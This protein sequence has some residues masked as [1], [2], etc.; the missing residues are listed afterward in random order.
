M[1]ENTRKALLTHLFLII[2]SS[3]VD[4]ENEN[5][6]AESDLNTPFYKSFLFPAQS[7]NLSID[8]M[9]ASGSGFF[10]ISM[11]FPINKGSGLRDQKA[12]EIMSHFVGKSLVYNDVKVK[13]LTQPSFTRLTNTADRYVGAVRIT[14][15]S[16]KL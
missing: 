2:P 11:Y 12:D 7:D 14:Y 6:N 1:I 9:E 8:T 3:D 5:P 16:Q 13:I 15:S 10:Q 4:T